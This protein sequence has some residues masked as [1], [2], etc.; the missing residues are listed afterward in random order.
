VIATVV[1]GSGSSMGVGSVDMQICGIV[2]FALG[3]CI[4]HL[5]GNILSVAFA[6]FHF[7]FE[8]AEQSYTLLSGCSLAS[9]SR[10]QAK[11]A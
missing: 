6:V 3:H 10:M 11:G 8:C 2:I 9:N 7:A 5:P 4:L 1:C